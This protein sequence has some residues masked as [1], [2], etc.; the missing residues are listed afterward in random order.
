MLIN[1]VVIGAVLLVAYLWS[2]KGFFSSFLNMVSVLAAGGVAFALWEPVAMG[3]MNAM[4]TTPIVADNAWAIGLGGTFAITLA[5]FSGLTTV[6]IKGDAEIKGPA[7]GAGGAVCGLV[8]GLVGV[9]IALV[10][11]SYV[12]ANPGFPL[13]FNPVQYERASG[14]LVRSND[15]WLP[16]DKLVAKL[17]GRLSETT[18]RSSTPL[19]DLRPQAES[20]GHMTRTGPEMMTMRNVARPGDAAIAGWY[21]VGSIAPIPLAELK[22]DTFDGRVQQVRRLDG[23]DV[24]EGDWMIAGVVIVPGPGQRIER[25]NQIIFGPGHVS[26]LALDAE[27]NRTELFQPVA[28]ISQA[29]AESRRLGRWRFDAEGVYVATV[30]G[31]TSPAMAFE[32]LIPKGSVPQAVMVRNLRLSLLDAESGE[33][34]KPFEQYATVADRDQAVRSQDII[35]LA[36][37]AAPLNAEGAAVLKGLTDQTSPLRISPRLQGVAINK[38]LAQSRGFSLAEKNEILDGDAQFTMAEVGARIPDRSLAVDTLGGDATTVAV[39]ADVGPNSPMSILNEASAAA[40]V[41]PALIDHLDQRYQAI[42]YLYKDSTTVRLRYTPGRPLESLNDL[43]AMSR[44]RTDQQLTMFFRVTSGVRVKQYVIGNNVVVSF[45]TPVP[46][47]GVG[48]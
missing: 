24:N 9:G 11:I 13:S 38:T 47:E 3:L 16:A 5:I 14:A 25:I 48:R 20:L 28:M 8:T 26:L 19:A 40:T 2:T 12:R 15:L 31:A 41:A 42:G 29:A 44:S 17:Y 23:S 37:A 18:L 27:G 7:N 1:L 34:R 21:T 32:F 4:G 30:G 46:V 6:L 33:P 22:K 45:A 10:S 35:N 36:A 39:Q 43:P